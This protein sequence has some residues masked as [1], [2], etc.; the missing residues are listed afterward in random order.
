MT[1][2]ITLYLTNT[3][4]EILLH[5]LGYSFFCQAPYFGTFLPNVVVVKT[6]KN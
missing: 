4:A 2:K 5:I 6:I 3:S 1:Q